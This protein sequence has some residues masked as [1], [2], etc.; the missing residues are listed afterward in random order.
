MNYNSGKMLK[1]L[2]LLLLFIEEYHAAYGP[3][4]TISPWIAGFSYR[5]LRRED[6]VRKASRTSQL[7]DV[8]SVRTKERR[9]EGW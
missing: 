8:D 3:C 2:L 7:N 4:G 5:L 9:R 6:R 1:L